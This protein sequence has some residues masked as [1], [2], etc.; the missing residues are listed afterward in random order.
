M[1]KFDTS[2]IWY[3]WSAII[4][5][6]GVVV[7][8]GIWRSANKYAVLNP[9]NSYATSAKVGVVLGALSIIAAFGRIAA[10]EADTVA[11]LSEATS[12]D[13]RMQYQ[14]L[15]SGINADLPKMVDSIT[16]LNKIDVKR[17]GYIYYETLIKEFDDKQK[18]Q[19]LNNL[20]PIL[21]S[22][23]CKNTDTLS[24]LNGGLSYTYI[25]SD[26]KEQPFGQLTITKSACAPL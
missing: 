11:S 8:V 5:T 1:S 14:A 19:L 22:G 13:E 2:V 9:K 15:I 24:S 3:A 18:G 26:S 16:R 20:K 4:I 21:A 6:Y 17:T 23:L 12:A 10:N 7:L 25:Y